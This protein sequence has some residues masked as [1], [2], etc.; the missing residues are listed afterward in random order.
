M[1]IK[2]TI[3]NIFY[4]TIIFII[5]VL[6]F[7]I[8]FSYISFKKIENERLDKRM[9]NFSNNLSEK[10]EM[11]N[12]IYFLLEEKSDILL[13]TKLEK[14]NKNYEI[15]GK[16]ELEKFKEDFIDLY[17]IDNN[18]KVIKSTNKSNIGLDFNKYKYFRKN[19][20][21]ILNNQKYVSDRINQSLKGKKILKYAYLPSNDK[22]YIFEASI[23]MDYYNKILDKN[24]I[25]KLT[26]YNKELFPEIKEINLYNKFGVNYITKES[27]K[28]DKIKYENIKKTFEIGKLYRYEIKNNNFR[29]VYIYIPYIIKGKLGTSL[30]IILELKYDNELINKKSILLLL[31]NIFIAMLF[32]FILLFINYKYKKSILY[33][34][35]KLLEAIEQIKIG[36]LNTKIDIKNNN[37]EI[38]VI[39]DAINEMVY[40]LK[41]VINEKEISNSL[42]EATL[43]KSEKGYLETVKALAT[44]IDAKDSYTGGHCER[45][46]EYSLMIADKLKIPDKFKKDLKFAAILHDIGKIGIKDNVLNKP[47]R[48]TDDEYNEIKKHPQIGY[49]ILKDIEFLKN[50]ATILLY[51]HEKLD[52]TG[53][54]KGISSKEI[55]LLSKIL[56]IA[57]SF[58]AMTSKRVY[59]KKNML[60][61]EAFEEMKRCKNQFEQKLVE[62]FIEA[63]IEKYSNK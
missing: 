63:Y 30:N 38:K 34:M 43:E 19:L 8:L 10:L 51:H 59:R 12:K 45:V 11:I 28:K 40:K 52:G 42:I 4:H 35:E 36:D 1:K 3:K 56:M 60:P 48:F 32:I 54:P 17:V 21:K 53:Y 20:E 46:M 61:E 33:P 7:F 57:D 9:S 15:Y 26:N 49:D 2:S 47:G 13:K 27:I 24:S 39:A 22:K 55:P 18:Y 29:E 62:V 44:A 6:F 5:I 25:Y 50:S 58:D 14:I 16:I 41:T 23:D 37:N 31:K